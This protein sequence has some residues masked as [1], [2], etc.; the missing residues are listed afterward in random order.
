MSERK[1][2]AEVSVVPIGTG[3][4]GVSEYVAAC[5]DAVSK[6]KKISYRAC[7]DAVSKRKKIS[8]RLNPMGTVL[9]G[10]LEEILE[11]VKEMHEVPFKKG[12]MRVVTTLKIDDRRDKPL[13]MQGKLDRVKKLKPDV[14]L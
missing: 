12:A 13:T 3:S 11:A 5:I 6:R 4:A 9:E 14:K 10:P 8:Y 2:V 1:I 7:I